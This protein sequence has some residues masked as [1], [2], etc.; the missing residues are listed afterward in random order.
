MLGGVLVP[1]GLFWFAWS[2]Y[3]HVHWIVPILES[4]VFGAGTLLTFSGIWTFL[5]DAY[6]AY[7]ASALAANNFLRSAFAAGFPLFANQSLCPFSIFCWNAIIDVRIQQC[8]TN[9]VTSGRLHFW[10]S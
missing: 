10:G 9:L 6:P 3:P 7:A 4:A 5:V 2:S 8:I 1:I